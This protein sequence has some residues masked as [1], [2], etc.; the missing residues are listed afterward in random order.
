MHMKPDIRESDFV[1]LHETD[2]GIA[3][4]LKGKWVAFHLHSIEKSLHTLTALRPQ[5][6]KVT[7]DASGITLIDTAGMVLFIQMQTAL[8]KRGVTVEV[9]K[10]REEFLEMFSLVTKYKKGGSSFQRRGRENLFLTIFETTGKHFY[11]TLDSMKVFFDF[12]G[13]TFEAFLHDLIHVSFRLKETSALIHKAGVTAL[14]IVG[15]TAFLIGVVIAFQSA[16][17]LQQYGANIF[18]VEIVSIAMARELSP[19]ITSIVI[20]GRSGSSFTAQIGA[21]KITEELDA[22]TVMGFD[23]FRFLVLPRVIALMIILPLLIFFGD[24]VGIIGGMVVAKFELGI[25]PLSFID[26]LREVFSMRHFY[27]GLIKGPFFAATIATIGC[28]RGLQVTR[29]TESIGKQ[30]TISVVNSIFMVIIIDALFSIIFT[31]MGI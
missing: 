27:A 3:V 17:Q 24:V 21:M 9:I 15:I 13:R 18:I 23:I 12:V 29:D 26:R 1:S 2:E 14:P 16:F 30:T 6:L 19:I 8:K 31:E 10:G 22:M 11:E 7:F 4:T 5:P 28:F 25:T 20:A